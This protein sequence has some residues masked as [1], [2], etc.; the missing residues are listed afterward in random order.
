MVAG[1]IGKPGKASGTTVEG[2]SA[3]VVAVVVVVAA[4]AV[5]LETENAVVIAAMAAGA[6]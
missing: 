2:F 1:A 6:V 3:P 5:G 4:V